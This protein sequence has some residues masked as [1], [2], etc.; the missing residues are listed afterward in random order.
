MARGRRGDPMPPCTVRAEMN[1]IGVQATAQGVRLAELA[2]SGGVLRVV[3]LE[4]IAP[5]AAAASPGA[6]G[7][8]RATVPCFASLPPAEVLTRVWT[9]PVVSPS[10]L[11][12]LVGHRLEADLPIPLEQLE[13]DCRAALAGQGG[14]SS[15]LAQAV[16]RE[17]VV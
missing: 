8:R 5:G 15:V 12:P 1:S 10:K 11:R 6:N 3:R 14:E 7:S 16:R 9:L 2:G 17:R 4:T 13:W